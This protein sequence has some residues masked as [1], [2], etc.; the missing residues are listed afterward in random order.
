MEP[1]RL[2]DS[3]LVTIQAILSQYEN[4]MEELANP[5]LESREVQQYL[6]LT[7]TAL[8]Y[9]RDHQAWDESS[10]AAVCSLITSI[11]KRAKMLQGIFSQ[12]A[13]D[14][15]QHTSDRSVSDSYHFTLSKLGK[16]YS[17]EALM[18]GI[19]K[20][21]DALFA[22]QLL[23]PASSNLAAELKDAIDVM[24]KVASS[25]KDG[26]TRSSGTS[27]TQHIA[28][29]GTGHQSHYSGQGQHINTGSGAMNNYHATSMNFGRK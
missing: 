12:V 16:S 27:F 20:D 1:R 26:D 15:G 23:V 5:P 13:E 2:L 7:Q 22:N 11:E 4:E 24:S 19:L 14:A 18:L 29:G 6:S 17:V 25:L 21:L 9:A 10:Q 3:A 28:S 8:H